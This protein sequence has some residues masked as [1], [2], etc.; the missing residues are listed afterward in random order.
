MDNIYKGEQDTMH[1]WIMFVLVSLTAALAIGLWAFNAPEKEVDL[2]ANLPEGVDA[3]LTIE[4]NNDFTFN[5]EVFTVYAGQTVLIK[6]ANKSGFHSAA[7]DEL[8]LD[9]KQDMAE[10]TVTF[11]KAGEEYL[12]YCNI[13]CGEGHAIMTAKLVVVEA[14]A[15]T[16]TEAGA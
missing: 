11:D 5:E 9:L 15:P 6:Y 3:L 8:G 10:T 7:I 12:I 14:P 1:K 16:D 13:P 2:S 4:A